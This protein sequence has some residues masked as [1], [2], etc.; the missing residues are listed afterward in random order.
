M[1]T[2]MVEDSEDWENLKAPKNSRICMTQEDYPYGI[3]Q[4]IE[5]ANNGDEGVSEKDRSMQP[6]FVKKTLRREMSTM[7]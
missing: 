6:S 1:E 4:T 7:Q 5:V 3:C 2:T